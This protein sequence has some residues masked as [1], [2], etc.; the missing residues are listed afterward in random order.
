MDK[1]KLKILLGEGVAPPPWVDEAYNEEAAAC[2]L[3]A[4][5]ENIAQLA[6]EVGPL[7]ERQ[8]EIMATIFSMGASFGWDAAMHNGPMAQRHAVA[9]AVEAKKKHA[10]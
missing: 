8:L 7:N 3:E 5:T 9:P 1:Q 4:F 10:D 2:L 6:D